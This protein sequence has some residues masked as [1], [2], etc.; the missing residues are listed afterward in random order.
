[1]E[2]QGYDLHHVHVR[3]LHMRHICEILLNGDR[4]LCIQTN[5]LVSDSF[6]YISQFFCP[7]ICVTLSTF[8]C[9]EIMFYGFLNCT[10]Q[11]FS[12]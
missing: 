5:L 7:E 10:F 11:Q 2:I 12:C 6:K 1:M 8:V 9:C 3:F 4:C